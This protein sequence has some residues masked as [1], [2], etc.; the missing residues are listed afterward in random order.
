MRL[1]TPYVEHGGCD[2]VFVMPNLQPPIRDVQAA[3][4]YHSELGKLAPRVQF[5]MSLYLSP[6]FVQPNNFRT[7]IG[8][9]WLNALQNHSRGDC[10][11]SRQ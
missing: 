2:T 10:S 8:D 7:M 11:S 5:L 3:L 1:V 6:Q 9:T 4:S